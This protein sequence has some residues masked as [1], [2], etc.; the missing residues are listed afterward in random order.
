MASGDYWPSS[1]AWNPSGRMFTRYS[2]NYSSGYQTKIVLEKM[3]EGTPRYNYVTPPPE[4]QYVVRR[5]ALE[6]PYR[7]FGYANFYKP[8]SQ[9][10]PIIEP[11]SYPARTTAVT[12]TTTTTAAAP[13]CMPKPFSA[14][15]FRILGYLLITM[16]ILTFALE[17]ADVIVATLYKSHPCGGQTVSNTFTVPW[18]FS[19]VV[20][21]IWGSIPI[22]ITGLLAIY[23]RQNYGKEFQALA[24]ISSLSAFFFAPA[25]IAINAAEEGTFISYCNYMSA[26]NA[27][28]NAP[29][30]YATLE[31]AKF[32]LPIILIVLGI[33]LLF[34]LLY[35]T[36]HLCY[37]Y[38]ECA[39]CQTLVGVQT[40]TPAA[41]V[42]TTSTAVA[43]VQP[44]IPVP[45]VLPSVNYVPMP[46]TLPPPPPREVDFGGPGRVVVMENHNAGFAY[47]NVPGYFTTLPPTSTANPADNGYYWK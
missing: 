22:F 30:G 24:I 19:W 27:G 1:A 5:S 32:A 23:V 37:S 26:G 7:P 3:N 4:N 41:P 34:L 43:P 44:A 6:V 31:G 15:K 14:R 18:F 9:P 8:V 21:G 2:P 35:L 45:I 28:S 11:I 16:S 40:A 36:V 38:D 17:I 47:A 20:P 39:M 46:V 42:V 12:T 10:I 33:I 25:I 13:T 29:A